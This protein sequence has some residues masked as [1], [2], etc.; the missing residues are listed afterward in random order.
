MMSSPTSALLEPEKPADRGTGDAAKGQA[1]FAVCS[2]C[3]GPKAQ[4][5]VAQKAPKL[6]GQHAWYLT[7]QIKNFKGG[8]RGAHADDAEGKLMGPIAQTLA[9]DSAIANV[10]AHIQ[11]LSEE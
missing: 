7:K 6:T 4:G 2:A 3:H 10:V 11:T 9:D 1:I 8:V 5:N